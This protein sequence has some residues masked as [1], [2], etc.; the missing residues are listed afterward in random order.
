MARP[1]VWIVEDDRAV[2]DAL[3]VLLSCA[4][5]DASTFTE[6]QAAI[7][8]LST[9]SPDLILLDLNLP[10]IDGLEVCRAARALPDYTPV[11]MLTARS[12]PVDRLIGLEVGADVYLTKPFEPR[13]LLAQIKAIFRLVE[14]FGRR[15]SDDAVPRIAALPLTNGPIV[16]WEAER[17]VEVEGRRVEL[18]PKEYELLR[19][20]L[21]HPGRAFGRETL[22]RTVWGY[23]F[24]GE[25]RT[26]DV[27]IQRLRQKIEEDPAQPR[28]L[29]TVRG[30]GYKLVAE[31]DAENRDAQ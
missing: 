9:T 6:G 1:R 31:Q 26:L 21:R 12:D 24:G 2:A 20:M 11:V 5:Y 22:L 27:H 10:D 8:A 7:R 28:W 15:D 29:L 3:Q 14:R 18:T 16:M 19:L 30:F 17:R 13:A 25:S 4:G 23:D